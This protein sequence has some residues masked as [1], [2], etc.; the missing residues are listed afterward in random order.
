M[1]KTLFSCLRTFQ[2]GLREETLTRELLEI[3]KRNISVGLSNVNVD[4]LNLRLLTGLRPEYLQVNLAAPAFSDNT[5]SFQLIKELLLLSDAINSKLIIEGIDSSLELSQLTAMGAYA[6]KG[7]MLTELV[8]RPLELPQAHPV[9][10]CSDAMICRSPAGEL[11]VP[12]CTVTPETTVGHVQEI[13]QH[14]PP[15]SQV[16]VVNGMRP[17]GL[18][19]K[20]TLDD[21]LSTQFG[22]ALYMNRPVAKLM[23]TS[24]FQVEADQPL[25]EV[26][27]KAMKRPDDKLYDDIVVT[28][29][30][31]LFGLLSVQ[32]M[33]DT[34]AQVQLELAKGANPLTGLPG[35]VSIETSIEKRAKAKEPISLAYVDLDNFKVYN[36]VYGFEKWRPHHPAYC[37]DIVG[38]LENA[39]H[40]RRSSRTCGWR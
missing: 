11:A 21:Q 37:Q 20:Y 19:M 9:A 27:Q 12:A 34:M 32:R 40:A 6:G 26:A 2:T 17:V 23:D 1:R 10:T 25:E 33:L 35:N 3:K 7:K 13:L 22:L 29:N 14:Q 28:K 15:L 31:A 16:V 5:D 4:T 30:G 36:D 24:F 18:I 8:C 38:S 39:W